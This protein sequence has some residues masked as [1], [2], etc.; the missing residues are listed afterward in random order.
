LHAAVNYNKRARDAAPPPSIVAAELGTLGSMLL[1]RTQKNEVFA[2]VTEVGFRPNDFALHTL[3]EKDTLLR[4]DASESFFRWGLIEKFLGAEARVHVY[5]R[6][7]QGERE[8]Y[9]LPDGT[10]P[11][12]LRGW[13]RR[14]KEELET[15]DLWAALEDN[16][17]AIEAARTDDENTPFTAEE[18]A[19]IVKQL[20]EVKAYAQTNCELSEGQMRVLGEQLDEL[21]E[22]AG[23]LGRVDWRAIVYGVLLG[24]IVNGV[25]PPEAVRTILMMVL[26]AV[27][28]LFGHPLPSL[29][30]G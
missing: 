27:A 7:E 17:E 22:A 10:W 21:A 12:L 2:A 19:E 8:H 15:P 28:H 9:Q 4:H 13:L 20:A 23:R 3:E 11:A 14:L 30:K 16:R 25:L 6:I 5:A 18:Q 1:S 24:D 26:Q 29:P